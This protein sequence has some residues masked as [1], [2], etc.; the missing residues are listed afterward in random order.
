[1]RINFNPNTLGSKLEKKKKKKTYLLAFLHMMYC[2][3][4]A[5]CKAFNRVYTLATEYL[6][7]TNNLT[8]VLHLR[9]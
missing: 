9:E 1:M 8:D 4:G 5:E 7:R 6:R 2:I 3:A